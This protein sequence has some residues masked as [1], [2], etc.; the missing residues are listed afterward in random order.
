MFMKITQIALALWVA[1]AIVGGSASLVEANHSWNGYH[2]NITA[3]ETTKYPLRI[4]DN[5]SA[6]WDATLLAVSTDWNKS[7]IK[8]KVVAGASNSN[9]DPVAGRTEVCNGLYGENGWLGLTQVWISPGTEPHI[10]QVTIRL[11]DS[12][13]AIEPF[14]TNAWKTETLCHEIGHAY[15]L[16]HQDSDFS[17]ANLGTCL[18]YTNDPDGTAY[19]QM[20]NLSPNQHDY[21]VI[22]S[23]YNHKHGTT[24]GQASIATTYNV[25]DSVTAI[26]TDWGTP[27]NDSHDHGEKKSKYVKEL[28]DGTKVVTHVTWI[29]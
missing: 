24:K 28:S 29:K 19:N 13:N 16:D 26:T 23:V 3:R 14:N 27:D 9:C 1:V 17:N 11:N 21:D 8:N 10:T 15:G 5:L 12:Y 25:V 20:S 22:K 7:V 4:G 6:S 2:W 18:D